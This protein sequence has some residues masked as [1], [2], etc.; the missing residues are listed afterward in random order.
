MQVNK[1]SE[2]DTLSTIRL[3][4][5]YKLITFSL[6]DRSLTLL[7][8]WTSEVNL[9]NGFELVCTPR[10][11]KEDLFAI[12]TTDD[13]R[14]IRGEIDK[15]SFTPLLRLRVRSIYSVFLGV[16]IIVTNEYPD[17]GIRI[18]DVA[19]SV[20]LST[21]WTL[22]TTYIDKALMFGMNITLHPKFTID[23][24]TITYVSIIGKVSRATEV[25]TTDIHR[26]PW[27]TTLT[28][29]TLDTSEVS[30][31]CDTPIRSVMP[32]QIPVYTTQIHISTNG[33]CICCRIRRWVR[34][35]TRVDIVSHST[36]KD[37]PTLLLVFLD[38]NDDTA[39]IDGYTIDLRPYNNL[40]PEVFHSV[41]MSLVSDK[42]TWLG[43]VVV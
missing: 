4:L 24:I 1:V 14:D 39:L 32:P 36:F 30:D 17:E 41:N 25:T 35:N 42:L 40:L 18:R 3:V 22:D 20:Y 19:T 26:R 7:T 23:K 16:Q 31:R 5:I 6:N 33:V 29:W 28:T 27:L 43:G 15:R 11:G 38:I 12:I 34:C 13:S 9:I 21:T 37:K 8:T 2:D 10:L